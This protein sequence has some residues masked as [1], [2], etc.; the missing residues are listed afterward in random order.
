MD[1]SVKHLIEVVASA[2]SAGVKLVVLQQ[3]INTTSPAVGCAST[4]S[5]HRLR[6]AVCR[7]SRNVTAASLLVRQPRAVRVCVDGFPDAG[8]ARPADREAK[9][10]RGAAPCRSPRRRKPVSDHCGFATRGPGGHRSQAKLAASSLMHR[11][12]TNVPSAR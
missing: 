8:L 11:L 4:C 12:P 2:A 10:R 3:G 7:W 5:E 6:R 9:P 1:R